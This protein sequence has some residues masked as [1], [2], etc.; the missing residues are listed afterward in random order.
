METAAQQNAHSLQNLSEL[1]D[2]T[3][4]RLAEVFK[5]LG[6]PTRIKLL[7]LLTTDEMRVSDIA[8]ALS[9][10]QSAISHQ[11]RVLRSARLV[12]FR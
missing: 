9:M 8:E 3:S 7:A 6:D 2:V 12:K 4:S 5:V 1:D 10:G 11:L